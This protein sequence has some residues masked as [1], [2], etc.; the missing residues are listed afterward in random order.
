M[1]ENRSVYVKSAKEGSKLPEEG[2]LRDLFK[3]YGNIV[4]FK[5]F[6]DD[7]KR[8]FAIVSFDHEE[9]ANKAKTELNN[10]KV[11]DSE[12]FVD[13]LMKK[14]ERKKKF[15]FNKILDKNNTLNNVYKDCN[16][17][18]R[19]LPF[20]IKEE[21]LHEMFSKFG[22]I[23]S[24]KIAKYILVTKIKNEIKEFP[25]SK[26]FGYV[27]FTD[28]NH[29]KA[30]KEAFNERFLPGYD[31]E[32]RPI[33]LDFFMSK[34]ERKQFNSSYHQ[35]LGESQKGVFAGG[36]TPMNLNPSMF[37]GFPP[38]MM[39]GMKM[40][41]P[42]MMKPQQ[43]NMNNNLNMNIPQPKV[44]FPDLNYLNSLEDDSAKK[45]YLGE[46][47][48][49]NIESHPLIQKH[50]LTMENIGKITGMILGIDDINEISDIANNIQHLTSRIKEALELLDQNN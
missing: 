24:I 5:T 17:H 44:E 1:N 19:N 3:K 45:E 6:K 16:L 10:F 43:M 22:E 23:R 20:S 13:N 32:K 47:I 7:S 42:N 48:F 41:N 40:H 2:A 11:K 30:A 12:L 15:L 38:Q 36:V 35:H 31:K 33:L 50:A 4:F 14:S 28:K 49:K 18:I 39:R 8:D 26:G 46:F 27:C 9:S 25:T 21:E 29:A 34:I 37:A